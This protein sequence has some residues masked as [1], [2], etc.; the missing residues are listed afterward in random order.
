MYW[1]EVCTAVVTLDHITRKA[2]AVAVVDAWLV[3][4]GMGYQ[5]AAGGGRGGGD[6]DGMQYTY[7]D[8]CGL[9]HI[10][11]INAGDLSTE[12]RRGVH[13]LSKYINAAGGGVQ[14][15]GVMEV[16]RYGGMDGCG[17]GGTKQ[18]R[19]PSC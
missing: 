16:W 7:S 8:Q 6:G 2:V 11:G 9:F 1:L 5:T 15:Y 18:E 3:G 13:D 17:G 4:M 19:I 14:M 10:L 12:R